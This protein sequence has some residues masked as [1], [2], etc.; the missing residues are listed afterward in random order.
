MDEN[1]LITVKRN[2]NGLTDD[3]TDFDTELLDHINA[4]L[5]I[6]NRFGIGVES[7]CATSDSVWSD[8]LGEDT[9]YYS[10]VKSYVPLKIKLF[11]D[12]P[13]VG[14]AVEALKEMVKEYEFDLMVRR[15]CPESFDVE[16]DG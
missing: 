7:F 8:F 1:I 16:D 3:N 9:Q 2:I 13:T 12:P 11:W 6:L 15:E 14:S 4:Q 10:M 5:R